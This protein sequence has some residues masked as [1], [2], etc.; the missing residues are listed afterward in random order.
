[1]TS[2]ARN[3]DRNQIVNQAAVATTAPSLPAALRLRDRLAARLVLARL[4]SWRAGAITLV[5]PEGAVLRYGD[6]ASERAVTITVKRWAFFWRALVAADIGC[7]ES[8]VEG[9]WAVSDL[10]ELCRLFLIDPSMLDAGSGWTA[11]VRLRHALLRWGRA[12]TLARARE[13]ISQHYD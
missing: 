10:V 7:G 3:F 5:L 8:Y 12:N 4:S 2:T 13:N 9:E 11:L 6:S 1:R